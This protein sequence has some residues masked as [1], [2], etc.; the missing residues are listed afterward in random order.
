MVLDDT[1]PFH[2]FHLENLILKGLHDLF[3]EYTLI[4]ERAITIEGYVEECDF[5]FAIS[6]QKLHQKIS[7]LVNSFVLVHFLPTV[8]QN[9]FNATVFSSDVVLP[10]HDKLSSQKELDLWKRAIQEASIQLKSCFCQL[11]VSGFMG[12][13]NS[14]SMKDLNTCCSSNCLPG[15][16]EDPLPSFVFQVWYFP[17]L[18]LVG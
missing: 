15:S 13:V 1:L 11:F 14:E 6:A 18:L 16:S 2:A 17:D 9:S 5:P 12:H 3:D 8:V 7:I 4:L 10:E